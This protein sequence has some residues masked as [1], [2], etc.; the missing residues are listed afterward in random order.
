MAFILAAV[1][2]TACFCCSI[3]LRR[4][5]SVSWEGGGREEGGGKEGGRDG[6]REGGGGGQMEQGM[7]G[8]RE[9]GKE[10]GREGGR[11]GRREGGGGTKR[12]KN[13]GRKVDVHKGDRTPA[14]FQTFK[15]DARALVCTIK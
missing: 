8:G 7:E 10:G 3:L 9:G 2:C 13:G 11:E 1:A 14:S 12:T 15:I 5:V 4:V 6:G